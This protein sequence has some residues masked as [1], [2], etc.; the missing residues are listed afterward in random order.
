MGGLHIMFVFLAGFRARTWETRMIQ[1]GVSTIT[2]GE[3][4][5]LKP[6]GNPGADASKKALFDSVKLSTYPFQL[7]VA[8][9]ED[10][11]CHQNNY[12]MERLRWLDDP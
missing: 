8:W 12:Q 7:S 10:S 3:C 4:L 11:P 1:I 2:S 9:F 6:V 5:K